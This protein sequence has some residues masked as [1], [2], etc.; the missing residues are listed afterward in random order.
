MRPD[1][2]HVFKEGNKTATIYSRGKDGYRVVLYDFYT[3]Y[4]SEAFFNIEEEAEHYAEDWV[5]R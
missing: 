2:L 5:L 4:T 3:E 1:I